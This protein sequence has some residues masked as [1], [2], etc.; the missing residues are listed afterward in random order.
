MKTGRVW[1]IIFI[2]VIVVLA[3]CLL[4]WP[5]R[6]NAALPGVEVDSDGTVEKNVTLSIEG[7]YLRYLLRQDQMKVSVQVDDTVINMDGPVFD[8]PQTEMWCTAPRYHAETNGFEIVNLAFADT[9]DTFILKCGNDGSVYV[10]AADAS[11]K[12]SELLERFSFI[13][14]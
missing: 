1:T 8:T 3:A 6:V 14:E 13:L 11:E 10:A 12:L 2:A 4:P 7:W 5:S 9:M